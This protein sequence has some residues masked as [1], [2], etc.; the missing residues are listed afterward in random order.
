MIHLDKFFS[1]SCKKTYVDDCRI[2]KKDLNKTKSSSIKNFPILDIFTKYRTYLSLSRSI[3]N[4][5]NVSTRVF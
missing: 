1:T 4:I 2:R 5:V 3:I